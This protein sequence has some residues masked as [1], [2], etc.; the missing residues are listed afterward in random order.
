MY[1]LSVMR[2][3]YTAQVRSWADTEAKAYGAARVMFE[4]E[5]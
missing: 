2:L 5:T 1:L 3:P 4:V